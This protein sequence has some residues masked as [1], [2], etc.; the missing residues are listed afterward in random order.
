M[1]QGGKR[2]QVGLPGRGERPLTSLP[3]PPSHPLL[4]LYT[5]CPSHTC[6]LSPC[7]LPALVQAMWLSSPICT[8]V[9]ASTQ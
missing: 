5:L 3:H 4:P 9:T 2:A 8:L 6:L 1:S 7:P